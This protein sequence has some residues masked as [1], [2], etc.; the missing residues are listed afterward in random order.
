MVFKK[1]LTFLEYRYFRHLISFIILA[2]C[3][4]AMT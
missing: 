4:F 2:P 1:A 3:N